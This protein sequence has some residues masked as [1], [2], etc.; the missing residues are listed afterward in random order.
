VKY[1]NKTV[2]DLRSKASSRSERISQA[3]F[4]TAVREVEREG[5]WLFVETPDHYQGFVQSYHLSEASPVK[6]EDWKVAE[7]IVPVEGATSGEIIGR[8]V[9]D[10]RFIASSDGDRLQITIGKGMRGFIP[11]DAV[12]PAEFSGDLM[13]LDRL[14]RTFVGTPYL[15]GGVSPFGFDCSGFVQRLFH[16]CFNEW[17]PRDACDQRQI[18]EAVSLRGLREGDL[19]FFPGHVVLYLGDGVIIHSNRHNNGVS[20]NQLLHA[21]NDYEKKLLASFE[22]ARRY[23]FAAHRPQ[24]VIEQ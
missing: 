3:L 18:G 5:D 6:G 15:W 14:A 9:F 4:N 13:D 24:S 17:L 19:C 21:R 10:T 11:R 8:V 2:V 1:V 12:V 22:Q 16:F 20:I 7:G 23:S